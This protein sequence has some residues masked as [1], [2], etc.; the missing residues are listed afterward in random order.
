MI[1]DTIIADDIDGD[2]PVDRAALELWYGSII[3]SETAVEGPIVAPADPTLKE[4]PPEDKEDSADARPTTGGAKPPEDGLCRNCKRRVRLNRFKLCYPCWVE[5]EI[6][7]REK[8]EGREWKP[9][10]KHPAWC[11]CEGL[12]EHK[13]GGGAS[14]GN[15]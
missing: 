3:A 7:D 4:L 13:S 14:R 10:D 9:G 12:G 11:H 15:N 6:I 8:K 1:L 2:E 5:A